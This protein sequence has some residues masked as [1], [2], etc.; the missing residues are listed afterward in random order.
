MGNLKHEPQ[1]IIKLYADASHLGDTQTAVKR[2][3]SRQPTPISVPYNAERPVITHSIS[4]R[5]N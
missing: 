1:P 4:I 3:K 2:R 5:T